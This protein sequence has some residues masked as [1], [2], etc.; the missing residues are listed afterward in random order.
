MACHA[1]QTLVFHVDLGHPDGE[2]RLLDDASCPEALQQRLLAGNEDNE[3]LR[4]GVMRQ[5]V[6]GEILVEL[7]GIEPVS[8]LRWMRHL[9]MFWL[10][11]SQ[12]VVMQEHSTPA[13][14]SSPVL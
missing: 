10:R 8:S 1:I 9:P 14:R 2:V 7:R 11:W 6:P 4:S 5:V 3:V 12:E 13:S